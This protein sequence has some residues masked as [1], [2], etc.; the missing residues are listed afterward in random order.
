MRRLLVLLV[1]FGLTTALIGC[2]SSSTTGSPA[3]GPQSLPTGKSVNVD[4]N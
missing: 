1:F 3:G 4:I 2:G